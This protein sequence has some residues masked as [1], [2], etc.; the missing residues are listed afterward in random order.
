[1]H[2]S[3]IYR[4]GPTSDLDSEFRPSGACAVDT[5]H[6]FYYGVRMSWLCSSLTASSWSSTV[7]A[8]AAHVW[9]QHRQNS[10]PSISFLILKYRYSPLSSALP[11]GC[12]VM[13]D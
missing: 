10:C 12:W 9:R 7:V 3:G 4:F 6:M 13:G 5:I 11:P 1:M 8:L 2:L